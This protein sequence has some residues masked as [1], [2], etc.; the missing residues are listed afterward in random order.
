[1]SLLGGPWGQS[2]FRKELNLNFEIKQSLS[3]KINQIFFEKK[4][5]ILSLKY[6]RISLLERKISGSQFWSKT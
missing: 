3:F 6:N 2:Q 1:M 5:L 4:A